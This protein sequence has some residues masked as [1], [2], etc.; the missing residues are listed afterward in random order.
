MSLRVEWHPDA[1]RSL[2]SLGW[3][4]A[5]KVDNAV[6]SFA[7]NGFGEVRRLRTGEGIELRLRVDPFRVRMSV[8]QTMGTL[9]VWSV[10]RRSSA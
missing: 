7:A 3:R 4:D 2:L 9:H 1:R 5:S 6:Q 8:D 10:R